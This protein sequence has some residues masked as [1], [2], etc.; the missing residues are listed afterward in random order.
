MIVVTSDIRGAWV[1]LG[2]ARMRGFTAGVSHGGRTEEEA[3]G[4][5]SVL[6]ARVALYLSGRDQSHLR[7]LRHCIRPGSGPSTLLGHA[8]CSLVTT[9][10]FEAKS[11]LSRSSELRLSRGN[12]THHEIGAKRPVH[13]WMITKSRIRPDDEHVRSVRATSPGFIVAHHGPG[14][15]CLGKRAI[16]RLRPG[17]RTHARRVA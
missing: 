11:T 3:R 8:G 12:Y 7:V 5:E 6:G 17:A 14:S 2:R 10:S 15:I 4:W 9:N 1:F 16:L 13:A